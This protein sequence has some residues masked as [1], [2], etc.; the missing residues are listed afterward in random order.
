VPLGRDY[1]RQS[2]PLARA[3]EVV[4][5][6]WTM[7]ILRDLFFGVR[8]FTELQVRLDIPRAVLSARIASLVERGL[9]ERRPYR[10]GRDDL[11][12]TERGRELWPMLYGLMQWGERH[13]VE[14]GP[15]RHFSHAAC[16]TDLTPRGDCPACGI[17]PALEE[18]ETRP[19]NPT[20]R[21]DDPVSRALRSPHRLLSPVK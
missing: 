17:E 19:G 7:L 5:E 13:L 18:I 20:V 3:L 4:G 9:V 8:R 16:G 12:L 1:E 21:R 15:V 14:D 6:R 10:A 2:C 11:V